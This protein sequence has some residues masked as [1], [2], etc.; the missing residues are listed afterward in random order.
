MTLIETPVTP[1]FRDRPTDSAGPT[2]TPGG[3]P[4]IW[5]AVATLLCLAFVV[6]GWIS[7][8]GTASVVLYVLSY[9]AGGTMA[10]VTAGAEL[11]RRRLSV[12]LLM[13]LAAAGAAILGD[14]AEG[15]VLL[16]LFSLSN[17]LE[18]YAMYR[19]TRSIDALI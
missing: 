16:F 17:T 11:M 1:A 2:G 8:P 12:D 14:W 13:I 6:A 10:A 15:A 3:A 19:T 5:S 18:A 4:P 7:G 9:A